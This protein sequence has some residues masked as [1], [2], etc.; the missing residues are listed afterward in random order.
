MSAA[1][2]RI[3]ARFAHAARRLSIVRSLLSLSNDE[4]EMLQHMIYRIETHR[5][6]LS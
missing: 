4:L 1:A 2:K 6:P 3:A 5:R